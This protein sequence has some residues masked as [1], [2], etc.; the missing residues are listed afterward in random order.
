MRSGVLI[1]VAVAGITVAAAYYLRRLLVE[2]RRSWAEERRRLKLAKVLPEPLEDLA[3]KERRAQLKQRGISLGDLDVQRTIG[4]GTFGRVRFALLD[5]EPVALKILKKHDIVKMQLTA[6]S[7]KEL[8]IL[9]TLSHPFLVTLLAAFQTESC[10][11]LLMP[12]LPGGELYDLLRRT[13]RFGTGP[14]R[15]Y[16]AELASALTYMHAR[17]VVCREIKPEN[18]VL[19]TDGHM[20]LVDFGFC[21]RL[22]GPK[23]KTFTTCG[24]PEYLAPEIILSK[25]HGL[26]C[27]WWAFGILIFEMLHGEPPFTGERPM[28]IYGKIL[29]NKLKIPERVRRDDDVTDLIQRLLVSDQETRL[30][31]GGASDVLAH[32]WF[33]EIDW[34]A[35]VR[36]GLTPPFVPELSGP[37]DTAK[38]EE[39]PDSV[40]SAEPPPVD[41]MLFAS[42]GTQT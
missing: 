36:R 16:A 24:T 25:G 35:V 11:Y 9:L 34:A 38:F 3:G 26:C 33:A 27:D 28:L 6:R 7:F 20:V 5:K 22:D 18:L 19:D 1:R 31:H 29:A 2:R 40:E 12:F 8:D 23:G 32:A 37:C 30:G 13:R 14:S 42:W 4:Q 15:F 17:N 41:P 10:N 39:Y 21:K